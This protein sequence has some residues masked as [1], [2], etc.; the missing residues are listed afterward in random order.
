MFT[1][2]R[3]STRVIFEHLRVARTD[4]ATNCVDRLE[5]VSIFQARRSATCFEKARPRIGSMSVG[6]FVDRVSMYMFDDDVVE[7]VQDFEPARCA[8]VSNTKLGFE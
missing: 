1:R 8:S 6:A 3:L 7:E 2:A 4:G 5:A